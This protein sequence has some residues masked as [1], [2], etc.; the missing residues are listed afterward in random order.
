MQCDGIATLRAHDEL[1][2]GRDFTAPGTGRCSDILASTRREFHE[3]KLGYDQMIESILAGKIRGSGSS[4]PTPRILD[5]PGPPARRSRS[6]DCSRAGH[7]PRTETAV[8]ADIVLPAAGWGEKEGTFINSERRFGVINEFAAPDKRSPTFH[9]FQ[10]VAEV[11]GAPIFSATGLARGGVPASQ[12][13]RKGLACDIMG[14]ADYR[15]SIGRWY[16]WRCGEG[17]EAG[18]PERRTLRRWSLLHGR[19][20]SQVHAAEPRLAEPTSA[21]YPFLLHGAGQI[22]PMATPDAHQAVCRSPQARTQGALREISPPD[23]RALGISPKRPSSDLAARDRPRRAFVTSCVSRAR[24]SC[25][26]LQTMN[27][28][29]FPAF[30]PY[31]RSLPT[32][33]RRPDHQR[34]VRLTTETDGFWPPRLHHLLDEDA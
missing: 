9:I 12:E 5:Q 32:R 13:A 23:A 3:S 10:L 15:R 18:C 6:V 8:R 24:S 26:A 30:D 17:R 31:S 11:G 28:L 22:E 1:V 29:T 7:V 16:Q 21:S 25:H 27:Q 20:Q 33:L 2:G 34:S 19:P 14:I 4:E